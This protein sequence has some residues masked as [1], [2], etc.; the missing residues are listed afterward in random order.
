M[1]KNVNVNNGK[2]FNSK[3]MCIE[4]VMKLNFGKMFEVCENFS[5]GEGWLVG[6]LLVMG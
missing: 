5:Q 2:K 1:Y 6:Q 4:T 3:I